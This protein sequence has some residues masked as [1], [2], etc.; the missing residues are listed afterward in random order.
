MGYLHIDVTILW[1]YT[2]FMFIALIDEEWVKYAS[3]YPLQLEL[4]D[5]QDRLMLF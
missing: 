5:L 4:K 1:C 3:H 2:M